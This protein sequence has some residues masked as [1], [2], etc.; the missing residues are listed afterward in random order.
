[1]VEGP[2]ANIRA[3]QRRVI[4]LDTGVDHPEVNPGATVFRDCG[5]PDQHAGIT[6]R[7]SRAPAQ[8][9]QRIGV[10]GGLGKLLAQLSHGVGNRNVGWRAQPENFQIKGTELQ[11]V[12]DPIPLRNHD[13]FEVGWRIGDKDLSRLVASRAGRGGMLGNG[14]AGRLISRLNRSR[15][16]GARAREVER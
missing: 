3:R 7:E 16:V 6:F 5:P 2:I 15:A 9:I 4:G 12:T 11:N 1:M 14:T 13:A 8:F 10:G